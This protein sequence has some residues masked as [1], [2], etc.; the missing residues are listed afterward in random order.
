MERLM[1]HTIQHQLEVQHQDLVEVRAQMAELASLL[2]DQLT[3]AISADRTRMP[4][5]EPPT[6]TI[7]AAGSTVVQ[8]NANTI[9]TQTINQVINIAPWDGERRIAVDVA[10]MAAALVENARLREYA[11]WTEHELTDPDKAPPYVAEMFMDLV[12]RS[13]AT[14][15]SRN[16]YLNPKRA[17]QALVHLRSGRWEVLALQEATRLMFDGV[18]Q[19]IHQV[20]MRNEDR[21]QLP[22]TAQNAL[23]L[24]EAMYW[25]EP[26]E[27]ARRMKA[28]MSAHLA[29]TAPLGGGD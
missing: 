6:S 25:D 10:Q 17:D 13:H 4:N 12:K 16:V 9:V 29:N 2:K 3:V 7:Q 11:R 1:E 27:Y 21:T 28:P 15:E 19:S 14:P 18:A 8:Q 24:G 22:L 26:D 20:I 23:S 5:R